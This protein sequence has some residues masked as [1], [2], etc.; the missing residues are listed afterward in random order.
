MRR[1][2]ERRERAR[3]GLPEEEEE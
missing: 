2:A 3:E 1:V